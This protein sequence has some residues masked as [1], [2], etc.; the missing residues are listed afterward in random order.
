M[1]I[2]LFNLYLFFL[3]II[4]HI[5]SVIPKDIKNIPNKYTVTKVFNLEISNNIMKINPPKQHAQ[6][7][8][9][10]IDNQNNK[11][12]NIPFAIKI[13][14]FFKLLIVF[15]TL[16]KFLKPFLIFS[17]IPFQI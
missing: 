7:I 4:L 12:N 10:K 9:G 15:F 8:G 14:K 6:I 2:L 13:T 17:T 3:F 11:Q 5:N 16:K 1:V